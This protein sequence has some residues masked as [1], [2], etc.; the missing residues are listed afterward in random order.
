MSFLK[1]STSF[2]R[3]R[4][5]DDVPADL[6]P[7]IPEKLRQFA[8]LDIDDIAEERAFGWTSFDDMLDTEWKLSPPEKADYL[9]FSLR[10]DT[11]RIPPAVLKKHTLIAVREEE[12][13]AKEQGREYLSRTR[14]K[15]IQDAVRGTLMTRFLPI[16]AEF[17]VV[18]NTRDNIVYFA[19]TQEKVIHLFTEF[20]SLTFDLDLEQLTPFTL[21]TRIMGEESSKK[22]E[23]IELTRFV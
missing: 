10:L 3:F 14:K 21:A 2:T 19:S 9:T 23:N 4:I 11:R 1:A 6:W 12:K 20:F 22:L 5:I 18:W 8:F 13:K 16:P 15:E 7:A 17:N